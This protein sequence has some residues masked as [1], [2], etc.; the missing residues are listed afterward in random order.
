MKS[1]VTNAY[2]VDVAVLTNEV[3]FKSTFEVHSK[4]FDEIGH[5]CRKLSKS[6]FDVHD[7]VLRLSSAAP[8]Y[9]HPRQ[10]LFS[11][12]ARLYFYL[13]TNES[14]NFPIS[15][16]AYHLY[17]GVPDDERYGSNSNEGRFE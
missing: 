3:M 9:N 8:N 7:N 2:N 11:E 13:F 5:A 10:Y 6:S 12:G 4:N 15:Y 14:V 16:F 17:V 1:C